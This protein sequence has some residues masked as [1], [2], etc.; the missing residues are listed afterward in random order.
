MDKFHIHLPTKKSSNGLKQIILY[1]PI[2]ICISINKLIEK[3]PTLFS[4]L[5]QVLQ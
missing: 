3:L 4:G 2:A 5:L 1:V